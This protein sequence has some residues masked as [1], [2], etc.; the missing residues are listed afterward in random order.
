MIQYY[1]RLMR[2]SHEPEEQEEEEDAKEETS[3]RKTKG[4]LLKYLM[5]C[6]AM[7]VCWGESVCWWGLKYEG[8]V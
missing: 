2:Y 7:Y 5:L 6:L 1:S 3:D 4:V 8:K